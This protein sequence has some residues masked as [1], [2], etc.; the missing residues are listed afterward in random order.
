M[1]G[2]N[3]HN[4]TYGMWFPPHFVLDRN[5]CFFVKRKSAFIGCR[6]YFLYQDVGFLGLSQI[7]KSDF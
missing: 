7:S 1:T 4:Q 3:T 2:F 6:L 5:Y